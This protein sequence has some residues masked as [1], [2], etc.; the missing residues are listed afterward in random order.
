MSKAWAKSTNTEHVTLHLSISSIMSSQ[1]STTA[2]EVEQF[3][4]NPNWLNERISCFMRKEYDR[5][6]KHFSNIL[7]KA[8][9]RDMGRLFEQLSLTPDLK[10]GTISAIFKMS[11]SSPPLMHWLYKV[12]RNGVMTHAAVL[13]NL[14]VKAEEPTLL[15]GFKLLICVNTSTSNRLEKD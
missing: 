3:R 8:E 11:G 1:S 5:S 15:A 6:Y 2:C 14:M 10:I 12:A 4:L 7:K 13:I 9:R